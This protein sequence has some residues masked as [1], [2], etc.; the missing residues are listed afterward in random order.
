M[1]FTISGLVANSTYDLYLYGSAGNNT[2][3]GKFT[4]GATT[5][6]SNTGWVPGTF[7]PSTA[8]FTSIQSNGSGVIT[9]TVYDGGAASVFNGFQISGA[10]PEPSTWALLAIGLTTVMALRRRRSHA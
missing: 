6:T 4:I 8:A 2:V 9:G 10:V 1:T 5:I 7:S 3:K